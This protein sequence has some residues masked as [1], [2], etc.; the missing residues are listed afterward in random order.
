MN[1]VP[2]ELTVLDPL[3]TRY[4]MMQVEGMLR[5]YDT[6]EAKNRA[7]SAYLFSRGGPRPTEEA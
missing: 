2:E 6:D 7:E 3:A 1:N 5:I 4:G